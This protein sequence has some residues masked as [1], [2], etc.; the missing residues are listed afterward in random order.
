MKCLVIGNW[1][2][3][4]PSLKEAKALFNATKRITARA[5][6]VSVVVCPP[7]LYLQTLS[8]GV[9]KGRLAFG[10]QNAHFDAGGAHTGEISMQQAADSKATHCL[11]GHAERR[12]M[13]ETNDDT[14][15]KVAGALAVGLTPVLCVGEKEREGGA[16]HF[17]FVREQL[18]VGLADVDKKLTKV[19]I[20]YEPLWTIGKTAAMQP[21][22]MHEM[23]IFIKKTL[24]EKFGEVGHSVTILYGGSVDASNAVAML[25]EGD[26]KGLLVGRASTNAA[27]FTEL[28]EAINDA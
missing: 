6:N 18:R 17:N 20:V 23:S 13:G 27:A 28:L 3:N 24:V 9:R 19:V 25:Q 16:E 7:S 12:E 10:V 4:P 1:K 15:K 2:M 11:I 22:D 8:E 26:V 21:R 14:R 5:R